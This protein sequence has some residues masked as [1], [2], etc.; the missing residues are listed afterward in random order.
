MMTKLDIERVL[1]ELL[2]RPRRKWDVI[3]WLW[4]RTIV[5]VYDGMLWI[6][7]FL[8][9]NGHA[10]VFIHCLAVCIFLV[11]YLTAKAR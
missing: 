9:G 5:L 6:T 7:G 2:K 11:I 3:S 4:G 1:K 8:T 10:V